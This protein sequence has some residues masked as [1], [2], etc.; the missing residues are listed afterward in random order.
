MSECLDHYGWQPLERCTH[1]D[2]AT[3]KNMQ[4]DI[5]VLASELWE[6]ARHDDY[7]W[8]REGGTCSCV[9]AVAARWRTRNGAIKSKEG[10]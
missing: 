8:S 5:R 6:N 1:C 4:N 2:A 3:I 10:S 9:L 7:C